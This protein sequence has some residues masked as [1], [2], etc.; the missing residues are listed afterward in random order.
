MI[1]HFSSFTY[2]FI[3][4]ILF[5]FTQVY[6]IYTHNLRKKKLSKEKKMYIEKHNFAPSN[7]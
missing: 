4:E 5:N 2:L 7:V 1:R 6:R 3:V